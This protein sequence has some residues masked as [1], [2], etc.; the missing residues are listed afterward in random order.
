MLGEQSL[1]AYGYM[2][3]KPLSYMNLILFY[4]MERMNPQQQLR[5]FFL[6]SLILSLRRPLNL[7][8]SSFSHMDSMIKESLMEIL[9]SWAEILNFT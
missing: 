4:S 5:S 9:R 1:D 3:L 8:N 6:I 7:I 2:K